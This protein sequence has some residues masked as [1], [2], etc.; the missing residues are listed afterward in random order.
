MRELP[1]LRRLVTFGNPPIL[2]RSTAQFQLETGLPILESGPK[3]TVFQNSWRD[4]ILYIA[5]KDFIDFP[6]NFNI[7]GYFVFTLIFLLSML[8][9]I[10]LANI[11]I[12]TKTVMLFSSE[13]AGL[14][15]D[16][17]LSIV[18]YQHGVPQATFLFGKSHCLSQLFA[19][20]DLWS[21]KKV[22]GR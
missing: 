10:H 16:L 7:L 20:S 2:S 22:V 19:V 6:F 8:F 17:I 18:H 9:W 5:F 4:K 12:S 15:Q 13:P 1:Y 14:S 21:R 3:K 11:I